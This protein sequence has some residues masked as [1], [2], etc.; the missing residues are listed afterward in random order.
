MKLIFSIFLAILSFNSLA[1]SNGEILYNDYSSYY[2]EAP[3]EVNYCH[4][5][6]AKLL[7]YL[8]G[9]GA[10][11]SEI[12]VLIIQQ[13]KTKPRLTPQNGIYDNQYAWHVVL[14]SDGVVYDLN[15]K[16]SPEG[17]NLE[18]YFGYVL[19]H[20]TELSN[21]LLRVYDGDYFYSYF[22]GNNGQPNEYDPGHFVSNFLSETASSPLV[23]ASMLKWY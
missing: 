8:K 19:G 23:L 6:H 9:R 13:D 22:Y 20:D 12:Y 14:L 7:K 15:A 17:V 5:N 21:V 3:Y 16:F 2:E 4:K 1:I 11:L 10:N 18:D